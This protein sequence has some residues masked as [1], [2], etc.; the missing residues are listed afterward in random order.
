MQ[1]SV[2]ERSLR[3]AAASRDQISARRQALHD[4]RDELQAEAE[5]HRAT[6]AA[7]E[8]AKQ[9]GLTD[10]AI[11]DAAG[12]ACTRLPRIEKELGE[13]AEHDDA[14]RRAQVPFAAAVCDGRQ[15]WIERCLGAAEAAIV[16]HVAAD[17]RLLALLI[18]R[19]ALVAVRGG[20]VCAVRRPVMD[21]DPVAAKVEVPLRDHVRQVERRVSALMT[22]LKRLGA[23]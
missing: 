15:S 4:R 19:E 7:F 2:I 17:K 5:R 1:L 21:A 13:I 8:A 6:L 23:A 14:L 18:E 16:K 22:A 10:L 11:I 20:G 9:R 12:E 3:E